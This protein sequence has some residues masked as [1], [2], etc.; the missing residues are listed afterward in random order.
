MRRKALLKQPIEF[1]DRPAYTGFMPSAILVSLLFAQTPGTPVLPEYREV[2]A[3]RYRAQLAEDRSIEIYGLCMFVNRKLVAWSPSGVLWSEGTHP[4][5]FKR[6]RKAMAM[7]L[8]F[9][10]ANPQEPFRAEQF[11]Y[12]LHHQKGAFTPLQTLSTEAFQSSGGSGEKI[13]SQLRKQTSKRDSVVDISVLMTPDEVGTRVFSFSEDLSDL[14][15]GVSVK[16][17]RVDKAD[18]DWT[19]IGL[20]SGLD[21]EVTKR[22]FGVR[23]EEGMIHETKYPLIS[24]VADY[25]KPDEYSFSVF[26]APEARPNRRFHVYANRTWKVTFENVYLRPAAWLTD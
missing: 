3:E 21:P 6:V 1:P 16:M 19:Y 2:T 14:P 23:S 22:W 9:L 18:R 4:E 17:E 20:I 25:N 15:P 10:P 13:A 5:E 12:V 26:C 24:R 7:E 8:S 11:L